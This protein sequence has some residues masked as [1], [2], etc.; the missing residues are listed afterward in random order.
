[1]LILKKKAI[2]M[3]CASCGTELTTLAARHS[4]LGS[5]TGEE[6]SASFPSR[7]SV[8]GMLCCEDAF[9]SCSAFDCFIVRRAASVFLFGPSGR[10]VGT[11]GMS[12]AAGV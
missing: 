6:V 1:M 2:S 5:L 11:V 9:N 12:H 8:L 10:G 7:P 4:E 3:A